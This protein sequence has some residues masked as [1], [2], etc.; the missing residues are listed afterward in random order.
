[1]R[2][3]LDKLILSRD[4]LTKISKLN[5]KSSI[6]FKISDIIAK[7]EEQYAI[8]EKIRSEK[9][10]Q[11]SSDGEKVDEDKVLEYKK[12]IED[13]VT[14]EVEVIFDKIDVGLL[15]SEIDRMVD[16]GADNLLSPGDLCVVD[17]ILNRG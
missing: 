6:L 8:F 4:S 10:K 17:W 2:I 5:F 3:K 7:V 16:A 11:Y 1:M 14:Q 9:V 13:M 15:S 12:E